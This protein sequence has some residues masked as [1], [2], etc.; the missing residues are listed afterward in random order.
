[1][2]RVAYEPL[3]KQVGCSQF[4]KIGREGRATHGR[5]IARM[6]KGAGRQATEHAYRHPI[7]PWPGAY[8]PTSHRPEV[9]RQG[10][11]AYKLCPCRSAG[12]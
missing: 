4:C 1:M 11:S 3:I 9:V 8:R 5:P 10:T 6:P 7:P 2:L 12:G